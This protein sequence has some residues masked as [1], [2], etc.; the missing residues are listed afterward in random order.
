M[1]R[2]PRILDAGIAGTAGGLD[3][4]IIRHCARLPGRS[5]HRRTLAAEP[6]P[7]NVFEVRRFQRSQGAVSGRTPTRGAR[8]ECGA[9]HKRLDAVGDP[10]AGR[11]DL[12][13]QLA[14]RRYLRLRSDRRP[15]SIKTNHWRG[16]GLNREE[17]E[18]LL[19]NLKRNEG[20]ATRKG[21]LPLRP[22][23]FRP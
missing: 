15:W 22:P 20:E 17:P 12:F 5:G 1:P 14:E 11:T 6:R 9:G 13:Q 21:C 23:A 7:E 8:V 2:N 10:V 4:N 16:S 19:P 3:E 18:S